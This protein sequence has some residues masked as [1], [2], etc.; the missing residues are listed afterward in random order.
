MTFSPSYDDTI[1]TVDWD[2]ALVGNSD[3]SVYQTSAWAAA[4]GNRTERRLVLAHGS[5]KTIVGGAQLLIR[6]LAPG[7]N[8]AYLPYGPVVLTQEASTAAERTSVCG[9]LI[10]R[11]ENSAREAGCAVLFIQPPRTDHTAVPLLAGRGYKEAP[12]QVGTSAGIE[13][14]LGVSNDELF[15]RLIKVRR[16]NVRRSERRGVTVHVGGS[17]HLPELHRLHRQSAERHGFAPMSLDYLNRQW[18]ALGR[19]GYLQLFVAT[20]DDQIRAAGTCLAFGPLAEFKLTGWDDSEVA[21][22]AC[23]N[24]AINWSMMKWAN[25]HGFRFFDLG[26][27]PRQLALD[28]LEQ[29]SDELLRG[30]PSEFKHGWGGEV[31]VFPT[32]YER[33]LRPIGH[34]AYRFPS[35]LLNND[36]WSGRVINWIRRT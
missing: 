23:I 6:R 34:L 24:D 35:R 36:G 29:G 18:D 15:S 17:E 16:R 2:D 13:V 20:I 10:E 31:K 27:L 21:R 19:P 4:K 14:P 32:T 7:V 26:G 5:E 11:A 25:D 8:A 9:D 28:A 22:K 12:V 33:L 1:K 30:T 3:G